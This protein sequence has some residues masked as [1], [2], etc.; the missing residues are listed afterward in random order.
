MK[1]LLILLAI[2]VFVISQDKPKCSPLERY[3]VRAGKCVCK[4]GENP[5]TGSCVRRQIPTCR[6]LCP[7]GKKLVYPCRCVGGGMKCPFGQDKNGKCIRKP[8]CGPGMIYS[9]KLK[10]CVR[11]PKEEAQTN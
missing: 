6:R 10:R 1:K 5:K 9:K 2:F 11:K 3:S 8:H 4:Y 7:E